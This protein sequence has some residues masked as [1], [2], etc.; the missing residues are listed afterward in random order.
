MKN[1]GIKNHMETGK[2]SNTYKFEQYHN[3]KT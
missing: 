1:S 2:E 3:R